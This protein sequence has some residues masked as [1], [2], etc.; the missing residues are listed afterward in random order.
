MDCFPTTYVIASAIEFG[1]VSDT[2]N[3]TKL[4]KACKKKSMQRYKKYFKVSKT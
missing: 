3:D 4:T 2:K 1:S